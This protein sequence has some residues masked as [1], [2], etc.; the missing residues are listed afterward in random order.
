MSKML[1]STWNQVR[2]KVED[3]YQME[4]QGI[5]TNLRV[6]LADGTPL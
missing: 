2:K 1:L 6:V 4:I 5:L 3:R